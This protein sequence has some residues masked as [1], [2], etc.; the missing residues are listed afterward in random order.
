MSLPNWSWLPWIK[1]IK[2]LRAEIRDD[3][4]EQVDIRKKQMELGTY[5]GDTDCLTGIIENNMTLEEVGDHAF[6]MV[7]AGHDTTSFFSSYLC[8][9][10]AQHPEVQEALRKVIFDHLGDK[11]EVTADDIAEMKYLH[12]VMQ[13]TLRLYAIIPSVTRYCVKETTFKE[14]SVDGKDVTIPKDTN[15]Y[16]PM[17][18]MNRDPSVYTEPAKF[19]PDRFEKGDYTNARTGFLPFGYGVRTCIGNTLAQLEVAVFI[20]HLLRRVSIEEEPGFK[21]N[22]AAGISL[23]TSNGVRVIFKN[24]N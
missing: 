14:A 12:K 11:E 9:L 1:S 4:V 23:T 16:I 20:C 24:L 7:G 13:E 15:L 10:L 21:V 18:L 3:L 17:F 19:N 2:S 5:E 8:L 6:T 22:I